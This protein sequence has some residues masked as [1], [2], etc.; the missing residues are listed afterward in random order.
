M[1]GDRYRGGDVGSNPTRE[2]LRGTELVFDPDS[3]VPPPIPSIGS[4]SVPLFSWRFAGQMG[5]LADVLLECLAEAR[6]LALC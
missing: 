5:L 3:L 4:V 1:Q 6:V 2:I